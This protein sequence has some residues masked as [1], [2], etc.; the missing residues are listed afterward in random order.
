MGSKNRVDT[1][2]NLGTY[3]RSI[4]TTSPQAQ[5]WFNR[6]LV[7]CYGFNH[8]EAIRCFHKA[9]AHDADCAMAYWGI[10]YTHGPFYNKPWEFFGKDELAQAVVICYE[11][12]QTA[13]TLSHNCTASEQ[14]LI[15][16]LSHRYPIPQVVSQE[17]FD[18]WDTAYAQAM[19]S[20]Y[21]AFPHDADVIALYAEAMMTRT[22]WKLWDLQTGQPAD[23]ADTV[24]AVQ[25]LE[26]GMTLINT[27]IIPPHPG[28][29]HM[30]IH[31]LEMS[32]HPE[33]A[34]PA[35]NMLRDLAPDS[36]HL[37]HMPAHI[38]SLC[39]HY[40]NA[41]IASEKAVAADQK[42]LAQVG[43]YGFYTTACCH[44]LHML[45]SAAMFLGQYERAVTAVSHLTT[46]LTPDVL[47]TDIPHLASTLE[48]YYSMNMHVLVRFGKWQEIVDAPLPPDPKLYIVT[49]AMFHYA[50]GVAQAA[51]GNVALAEVEK[52]LLATA[53]SQ[54]PPTRRFFNNSA[55]DILAVAA[56]MLDGELAY[57]QGNYDT[58]YDHLRQAVRLD[59]NLAY[60]EPW[61]WMHPPRHALGALLLA[62]GH[63]MEAEQVY[64]AD[65]GLDGSLQR[66]SQHPN[67]VWSLHG[68]HECLQRLGKTAEAAA[69]HPQLTRALSYTDIPITASCA[70]RLEQPCCH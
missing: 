70:C 3:G 13:L 67:N 45:M 62:Q 49:T 5:Q 25:V 27:D 50:K 57:R 38:D 23:G 60:T 55:L 28:I 26:A 32:P 17:T 30:T 56:A 54:I 29:L 51:L 16:A 33:R 20:V 1:Y 58:A 14:V 4:T 39:G 63:V 64:R 7:W 11:A 18:S 21:A 68:Y 52:G 44:D 9:L 40:H 47:Q 61:A 15:Q 42:Y 12:V 65:L 43:P 10:A 22:P 8:E 24:T 2:Y 48:G 41:V 31:A 36:G 6:G 37:C 69:L 59:D 34:L 66:P 53:V 35:A 46:L 19:Q